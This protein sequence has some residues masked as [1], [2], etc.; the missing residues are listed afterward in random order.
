M[1]SESDKG[2]GLFDS[3]LLVCGSVIGIGIFF[4]PSKI[5]EMVSSPEMFLAVWVVGGIFTLFACF[6][7]AEMGAA[8]PREG[9]SYI[10]LLE[11]VGPLWAFLFG[12]SVVW[13]ASCG[14]LA[15]VASMF[16]SYVDDL[17]GLGG[18]GTQIGVAM[19]LVFGGVCALGLRVGARF[20]SLLMLLKLAGIFALLY[21]G[22]RVAGSPV[23][24]EPLLQETEGNSTG[25]GSF[26]L[27]LLPALFAYM[28]WAS[29]GNITN[30]LRDPVR[31]LPRAILMGMGGVIVVYVLLAAVY[32][33]T[34]G[35]EG[36]R[37]NELFAT[38]VARFAF[39]PSG[40]ILFKIGFIISA[41][42]VCLCS[43]LLLPWVT[44]AMAKNGHFFRV[45][46]VVHPKTGAPF[47]S[48]AIL[49]TASISW[50]LVA[51][52]GLILDAQGQ[53]AIIID[54]VLMG[55][56][57]C[58]LRRRTS[59][60][61]PYKSPFDPWIPHIFFALLVAMLVTQI[62]EASFELLGTSAA[63]ILSGLVVYGP[64]RWLVARADRAAQ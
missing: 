55:G 6:S 25:V 32:L 31:T 12:W 2:L 24:P 49:V 39:G 3:V 64:W 4:T 61:R 44:V 16:G 29:L 42:G 14:G 47:A 46:G 56:Y 54:A 11:L 22:W 17:F 37:G 19:L 57:L 9:G 5:A 58:A 23:D 48:L 33:H 38:E 7:F 53:N 40:E 13:I 35:L 43:L 10:Y 59:L 36:L 63:I 41:A 8:Y 45:F 51:D 1:T 20:Q 27:A 60:E 18:L 34:V 26:S 30:R 28:G 21:G 50:M 62:L 52:T 15:I